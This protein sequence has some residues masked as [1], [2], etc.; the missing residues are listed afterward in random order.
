MSKMFNDNM[1][2]ILKAE[3]YLKILLESREKFQVG[4]PYEEYVMRI[5]DNQFSLPSLF[6]EGKSFQPKPRKGKAREN[7]NGKWVRKSPEE[8]TDKTILIEYTKRNGTRVSFYRTYSVY[9]KVMAHKYNVDLEFVT[10]PNGE[11]FV[12][13]P[14]LRFVEENEVKNAF[15]IN[16]FLQIFSGFEILDENLEYAMPVSKRFDFE[17]LPSGVFNDDR[18]RDLERAGSKVFSGDT[19]GQEDYSNRLKVIHSHDAVF[20]GAGSSGFNGYLVFS[21]KD[22]P[23]VLVESVKEDNATY[24]FDKDKYLD[25]I[26]LDKQTILSGDLHSKRIYHNESWKN[27]VSKLLA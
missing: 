9:V 22:K 10:S 6:V 8:R 14:P 15:I 17:V 18:M 7:V 11:R 25:L 5:R 3:K 13:S 16:L 27:K 12:V 26:Q 20:E 24:V 4:I 19:K 21:F 23:F 2:R 1:S